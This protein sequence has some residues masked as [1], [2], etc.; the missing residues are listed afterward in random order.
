MMSIF[1]HFIQTSFG[2]III[3]KFKHSYN[4]INCITT[5][6]NKVH[7]IGIAINELYYIYKNC[8]NILSI[9]DPSEKHLDNF[10]STIYHGFN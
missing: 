6:I 3:H 5:Y 7:Y 1:G 2:Y 4:K 8:A 9:S 10:F